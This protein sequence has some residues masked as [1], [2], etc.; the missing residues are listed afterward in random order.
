MLQLAEAW[1]GQQLQDFFLSDL[2]EVV[3]NDPLCRDGRRI[4]KRHVHPHM[5]QHPEPCDEI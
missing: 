4:W 5:L 2:A 3:S 1:M